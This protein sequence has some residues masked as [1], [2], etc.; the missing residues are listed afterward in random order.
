MEAAIKEEKGL[1]AGLL[2]SDARFLMAAQ[3]AIT[4]AKEAVIAA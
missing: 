2:P 1:L 3:F 4:A